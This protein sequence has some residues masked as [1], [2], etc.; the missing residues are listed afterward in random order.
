MKCLIEIYGLNN[1]KCRTYFV[2][3]RLQFT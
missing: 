2:F 3:V 1:F